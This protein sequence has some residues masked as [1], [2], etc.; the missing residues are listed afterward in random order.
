MIYDHSI[1]ANNIYLPESKALFYLPRK[2]GV[3]IILKYFRDFLNKKLA[4]S[5][6]Q[7]RELTS[8]LS[9]KIKGMSPSRAK[10]EHICY[11]VPYKLRVSLSSRFLSCITSAWTSAS[12]HFLHGT[13]GQEDQKGRW[14]SCC[15]L[16]HEV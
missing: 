10:A 11:H 8:L 6:L 7:M 12:P 9:K 13:W 1:W 4:L 15:L 2:S 14:W 16:C 3:Q 5:S